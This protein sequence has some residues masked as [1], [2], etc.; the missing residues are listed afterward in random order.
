MCM[1]L[2]ELQLEVEGG[3]HPIVEAL[4]TSSSGGGGSTSSG[5]VPND[6]S[7]DADGC[8]CLV[9]TGPSASLYSLTLS[10]SLQNIVIC[11]SPC[12]IYADMGGKSTNLR[13]LSL[14][15]VMAQLG[16]WV[17]AR[18][19][20]L[21]AFDAIYARMGAADNIGQGEGCVIA[22]MSVSLLIIV[23]DVF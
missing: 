19:M 22:C 14:L 2:D 4:M 10:S 8:R 17:P 7:L 13:M 23:M 20:R 6:V 11:R 1:T 16:S 15:V 3:R 21:G 12:T 5:F 18:A 9:I